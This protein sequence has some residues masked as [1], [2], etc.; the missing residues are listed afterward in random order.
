MKTPAE[1]AEAARA[2]RKEVPRREHARWEP[3]GDRVDPVTHLAAQEAERV[4]WLLPVRHM[5]MAESPFAFFRG[6]AAPMAADLAGTPVTGITVQL[7]GDAHL[8]NFGTFASPERRQVFDLNDFDETLPG[9]W[10][11]DVK[12]LAASFTVAGRDNGFTDAEG[13]TAAVQA[14]TAYRTA[15][16]TFASM[17][18]LEV[19]YAQAS[20][21]LIKSTLVVDR[22]RKQFA[23]AEKKARQ[24]TSARALTRLTE[25]SE[26]GL[27]IR[28]DPPLLVPLREVRD[29]ETRETFR[30]YVEESFEGYLTSLPR[31]RRHVLSHFRVI[32]MALKVVGVGSVGT[33]CFIVLLQGRDHDEPLFL[34][35]KEANASV[36]EAYLSPSEFTHRGQ[37]VVEG[38]RLMQSSSDIFLGWSTGP[39][40]DYYWRQLHDMKGAADV[41]V[42]KP[43]QLARYATL[44]GWTLAHG[45]A[46]SG[47]AIAIAAYLGSGDTF[48]EAVGDFAVAYADQTER[49][50][51]AFV[52]AVKD[53]RIDTDPGTAH[54]DLR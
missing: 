42:M 43:A 44:C 47:D 13:R 30:H 35:V 39:Q 4:P 38:Q 33:R 34:Q 1:R 31:D 15:M 10:E 48:A 6:A 18:V 2:A 40:R 11:W 46:R 26:G 32:D 52:E 45:H 17:S 37:R 53:G 54:A 8:A 29:A 51:A 24:R 5:R 27:Q 19:W 7:C 20:L 28:S 9:P 16:A 3:P 23:Q 49:D 41:T 22:Y 25:Q 36:L 14:V 21:E 50:Y 12:R